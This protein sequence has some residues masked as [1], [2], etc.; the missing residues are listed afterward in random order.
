MR[1]RLDYRL[2][3]Y[4]MCGVLAGMLTVSS[5]GCAEK[6]IPST[7]KLTSD[8]GARLMKGVKAVAVAV[9]DAQKTGVINE[10]DTR[11][12]LETLQLV[13]TKSEE[14]S[15][16]LEML[17]AAQS[18]A[19]Q[20]TLAGKIQAALDFV[21]SGLFT[22]LVPIKDEQLKANVSNLAIEVS[23]TVGLINHEILE[24]FVVKP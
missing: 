15:S 4:V 12:V 6:T 7:V 10:A 2:S 13:T 19:D 20:S 5:T 8:N 1:M 17:L 14:A 9:T 23:K 21:N 11:K 3:L 24:R 22:A 16:Y 18:P